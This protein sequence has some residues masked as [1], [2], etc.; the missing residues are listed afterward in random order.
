MK[1][2]AVATP[3]PAAAAAAR[4]ILLRGG[5]AVDAAVGAMLAC[6]V[7]TPGAVGLG[8][9]GGSL[10]AYLAKSGRSVAIDFD[11]RAPLAY[12]A[13]LFGGDAQKFESGVLSIT[14]PAV[15]AGLAL[16]L[17]RFGSQSWAAVSDPAIRLAD[18]GLQMTAH[19]KGQ[20][21]EWVR[22]ADVTSRRA[23]FPASAV[24]EVG[25]AWRQPDLAKLLARL[26]K[27]GPRKFYEGDIPQAIVRQVRAAGGILTEDD[28]ANYQSTIVEPLAIAYRGVRLLTPPPPSGG[29][30]TLQILKVLEQFELSGLEPWGAEYFHLFA[31]ATKLAWQDRLTYFGDPDVT[32]I[33]VE[34]LLSNEAAEEKASR[35]ALSKAQRFSSAMPPSPQH[36]ANIVVADAQGNVVSV[37]ATQGYLFGSQVAIEGLGL[38][39]GHGM[40]RFDLAEGSPNAPAPGKRMFHN[41][42]PMILLSGGLPWAAVGLPGGPK[43]VTVT[44]QL[45]V[46]LVDFKVAPHVAVTAPRV[47]IEAD[48]PIAVSATLAETVI[49]QLRGKGHTVTRG[50]TVGGL[51]E[52]I[53]GKANAIVIDAATRKLLAASQAGEGAALTIDMVQQ[54]GM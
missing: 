10:V 19:L 28:F 44:A 11:S 18:S 43:I 50:Q 48:E 2:S 12:R 29:L 26:A 3:H 33:P 45:V 41:M 36:T 16:A 8:G 35:I 9:Y 24:P 52:E 15:V 46:S 51:P 30:T 14:V 42:A 23:L 20:V 22:K 6:C 49:E 39:M 32:R 13:E 34:Q 37:T 53:G 31:E 4:D 7:A 21:E 40:S 25:A 27:Y 54:T 1:Q 47:H 5:N 17:E 38:V